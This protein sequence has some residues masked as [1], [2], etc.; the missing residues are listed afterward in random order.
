MRAG[1]IALIAGLIASPALAG[2]PVTLKAEVMDGDGLVTLS[3]L[4]D[5][6]GLAAG[7][8]PVAA[9]PG[10]SVVLDAATVQTLARRSGLDWAN[11]E[12]IRR[13]IVRGGAASGA[14]AARGN[15]EVL[16]YARSL[17]TGET[18]QPQDLVW[19]KVAA[20]AT[21][22]PS[23][24]DQVV[25]LMARRPLRAGAPVLTRDVGAP[26]V[27]KAGDEV[28]V[29]FQSEGITLTLTG[30]AMAAAAIGDTFSVQNTTSKKV[31]QAVATGAG[32]AMT[33]PAAEPLKR[34]RPP[35]F[36]AR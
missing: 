16:T 17:A 33:G 25:G 22:A 5:G 20:A 12:G 19:A 18:I 13:I 27:I 23:D 35:Q 8:V 30:K 28:A 29:T 21:D 6:A 7:K 24:T 26:Q 36:A 1:L 10:P 31:I 11:A 15:V 14:V 3:D 4:F 32:Q 2:T 9:R 34:A